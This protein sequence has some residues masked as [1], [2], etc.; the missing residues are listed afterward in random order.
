MAEHPA[1]FAAFE[2]AGWQRAAGPYADAFG[3]L[4]VQ[5][6]ALTSAPGETVAV[7]ALP[8]PGAGVVTVGA[9]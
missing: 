5:L 6:T 7:T 4:T 2:H 1:D 8:V 3:P 9:I